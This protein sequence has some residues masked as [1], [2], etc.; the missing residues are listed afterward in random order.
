[1][2]NILNQQFRNLTTGVVILNETELFM[3]EIG[4]NVIKGLQGYFK[5]IVQRRK[6]FLSWCHHS[7]FMHIAIGLVFVDLSLLTHSFAA[8][9][10]CTSRVI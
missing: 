8:Q 7:T 5:Y 1:M 9:P 4:I 6:A 3:I 10:Y 2:K